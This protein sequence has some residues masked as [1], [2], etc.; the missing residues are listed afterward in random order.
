MATAD[1]PT[2]IPGRASDADRERFIQLLQTRSIE[3]RL[4]TDTFARRLEGCSGHAASRS[5]TPWSPSSPAQR[6][7]PRTAAGGLVA[8]GAQRRP[9][10]RLARPP[11]TGAGA[12]G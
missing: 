12:A 4:S 9:S 7:T 5:S 2:P 1:A 8:L 3:G 10:E 6:P 11:H